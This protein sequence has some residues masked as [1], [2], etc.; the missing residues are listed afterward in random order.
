MKHLESTYE[1]AHAGS[2]LLKQEVRTA[3]HDYTCS[4]CGR[5]VHAGEEYLR[6]AMRKVDNRKVWSSVL[7]LT[8]RR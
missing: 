2:V 4:S 1:E 3:K 7:H 5:T 6:E 8:C